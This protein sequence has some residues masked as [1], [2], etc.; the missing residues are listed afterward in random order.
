MTE[1]PVCGGGLRDNDRNPPRVRLPAGD[2]RPLQIRQVLPVARKHH[3]ASLGQDGHVCPPWWKRIL[4]I[5]APV[6][7]SALGAAM[8]VQWE[9]GAGGNFASGPPGAPTIGRWMAE[10]LPLMDGDEP[11]WWWRGP[12]F[13]SLVAVLPF[14]WWV[15]GRAGSRVA[16]WCTRGG[17]LVGAAAVGLQYST[18]GYGWLFDLVALS[19]AL[20]GTVAVGVS[21][22]RQRML[23]R[24][25]A[26]SLIAA[27][28]LTPPAGLLVFWYLPPGLTIGLLIGWALAA[29]LMGRQPGDRREVLD[30]DSGS[31]RRSRLGTSARLRGMRVHSGE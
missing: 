3:G 27:L 28:P 2:E 16:R 7:A 12:F 19:L 21:A 9:L 14:A 6:W 1:L 26:W 15:T 10:T 30:H 8:A 20:G 18:P 29:S 11:L 31:D 25:V 24:P 5:L 23:P 22:L 17:L 4:A 13:L